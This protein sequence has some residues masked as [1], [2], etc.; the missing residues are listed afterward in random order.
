[1]AR[2]RSLVPGM[3]TFERWLAGHAKLL[4]LK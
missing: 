2:C 3:Q 4:P 1:V